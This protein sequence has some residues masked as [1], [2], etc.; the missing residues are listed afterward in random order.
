[1]RGLTRIRA[2]PLAPGPG[3]GPPS[4]ISSL[5]TKSPL[6]LSQCKFSRRIHNLESNML[7]SYSWSAANDLRQ[8]CDKA[9]G[10]LV[11]LPQISSFLLEIRA[12]CLRNDKNGACRT[13]WTDG[14]AGL[15]CVRDMRRA[16]PTRFSSLM[17][18]RRKLGIAGAGPASIIVAPSAG[19]LI[20]AYPGWNTARPAPHRRGCK[21]FV[22][23]PPARAA[24]PAGRSPRSPWPK[25]PD[26]P[27]CQPRAPRPTSHARG[28]APARHHPA[29]RAAPMP[30]L[31]DRSHGIV[32][33]DMQRYIITFHARR[34]EACGPFPSPRRAPL[35]LSPT[36]CSLRLRRIREAPTPPSCRRWEN[37][38]RRAA[39]PG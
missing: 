11:F 32:H 7:A 9:Q 37:G 1:M 6:Q 33:Y 5:S 29:R 2:A 27:E 3:P 28:Q 16:T 25:R 24:A 22:P 20:E 17:M 23:L 14:K 31:I 36:Q 35:R 30:L 10:C 19:P 38:C 8:N 4:C 12:I 15:N 34:K 21:A 18:H 39:P 26:V 13:I